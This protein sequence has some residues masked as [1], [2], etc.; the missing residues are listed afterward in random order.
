MA[1]EFYMAAGFRPQEDLHKVRTLEEIER[2][3]IV[4][5]LGL[6]GGHVLEAAKVLNVSP[7]T[8]YRKLARWQ[9]PPPANR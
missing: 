1:E 8:L 3:Y 7:S 4:H 2:D 6:C 9:G 5:V